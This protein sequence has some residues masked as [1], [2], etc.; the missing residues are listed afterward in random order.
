MKPTIAIQD[1]LMRAKIRAKSLF[2]KREFDTSLK[3]LHESMP[4][5]FPPEIYTFKLF[6]FAW[7]TVQARAF[8]KRLKWSAMVPLAGIWILL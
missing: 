7:E 5:S 3:V 4:E 1:F 8:G 6:K 2:L